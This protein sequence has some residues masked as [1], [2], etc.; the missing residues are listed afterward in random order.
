MS[1]EKNWNAIEEYVVRR[2]QT[3]E[4]KVEQLTDE[5]NQEKEARQ[6]DGKAFAEMT[7]K[8]SVYKFGGRLYI[9]MRLI[10]VTKSSLWLVKALGL[11]E[12]LEEEL[13]D[14]EIKEG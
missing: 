3:L 12:K 4:A 2:L 11:E 5:L 7:A 13:K 9:N 1:E 10:E 6:I 8:T 14:A